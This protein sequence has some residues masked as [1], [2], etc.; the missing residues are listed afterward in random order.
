ME[1]DTFWLKYFCQ[2]D[3]IV[4]EYL[5]QI[6]Q[7]N[8]NVQVFKLETD[9]LPSTQQKISPVVSPLQNEVKIFLADTGSDP[10]STI[11][12]PNEERTEV[13]PTKQPETQ[14]IESVEKAPN[15]DPFE[16][17][18]IEIDLDADD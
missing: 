1:E 9:K 3:T 13:I 11:I 14:S 18:D 5:N 8:P 7:Q 10:N 16:D 4:R 17:I 2:V 15:P 12:R 6:S